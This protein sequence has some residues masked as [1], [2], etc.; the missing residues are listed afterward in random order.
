[1]S[2]DDIKGLSGDKLLKSFMKEHFDFNGLLKAGF[3][4]KE[5]RG[6]YKAQAERVCHRFGFKTVYEYGSIEISCHLTED[7]A[8]KFITVLP[9][10][11]KS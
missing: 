10:I 1:M 8:T 4:T 9:N 7:N 11:Y 5:M 3:F 6:D 2:P